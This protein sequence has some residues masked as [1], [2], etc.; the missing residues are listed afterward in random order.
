MAQSMGYGLSA[1]G[2]LGPSCQKQGEGFL[3]G[4]LHLVRRLFEC[5]IILLL[6]V[7]VVFFELASM[8]CVDMAP[9]WRGPCHVLAWGVFS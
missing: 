4:H 2:L 5:Q 3:Y 1:G 6:T 7:F 9:C 8:F